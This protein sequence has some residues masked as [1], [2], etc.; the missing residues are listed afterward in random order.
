LVAA[1]DYNRLVSLRGDDVLVQLRVDEAV[2]LSQG[3]DFA[4]RYPLG[5]QP[6]FTLGTNPQTQ[7]HL[8]EMKDYAFL[9]WGT[10]PGRSME[11]KPS[12]L[13]VSDEWF[14]RVRPMG[15]GVTLELYQIENPERAEALSAAVY[16]LAVE[17]QKPG[18]YYSSYADVYSV[19]IESSSLLLF[20]GAFL[21]LIAVF[22]LAS[23]IYFRQLKVAAE[24]AGQYAI[25]RKL[26]VDNR[27]IR[28]A[29]RKQLVFIFAPPLLLAVAF[30]WLIIRYY[31]LESLQD[32]PD[33]PN[34]VW[35]ILGIYGL[36]YL[37]FYFSS[38]NLYYRIINQR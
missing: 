21:A 34:M 20:A 18:H 4:S 33:L 11:K 1:E 22:A 16:R 24:E 10:I 19:Q 36:V 31:M 6:L 29:I 38:A 9:G 27:Q 28:S 37:L 35:S 13:V 7:V 30:S 5:A 26:G 23:V 2:S 32:F 8:T 17:G 25:L 3:T 12:V 15:E 14:Q